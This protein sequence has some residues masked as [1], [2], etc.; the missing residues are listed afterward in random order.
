VSYD[1]INLVKKLDKVHKKPEHALDVVKGDPAN[2]F[3]FHRFGIKEFA[4]TLQR[5]REGTPRGVF[6]FHGIKLNCDVRGDGFTDPKNQ[7]PHWLFVTSCP[8]V[9]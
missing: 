6:V 7:K 4:V 8:P 2:F 9:F 3:G 5:G 1:L